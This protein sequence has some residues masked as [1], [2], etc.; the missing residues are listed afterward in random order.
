MERSS[1]ARRFQ[2]KKIT[3]YDVVSGDYP[4][5]NEARMVPH[6][7]EMLLTSSQQFAE[8]L[9]CWLRNG[10]LRPRIDSVL[11]M[12][13]DSFKSDPKQIY[14]YEFAKDGKISR[15]I[16]QKD[17]FPVGVTAD[18]Q[19][20]STVDTRIQNGVS[21]IIIFRNNVKRL[22]TEH[23]GKHAGQPLAGNPL[24]WCEIP[25]Y[26]GDEHQ[27]L[28]LG[29]GRL[30]TG[31]TLVDPTGSIDPDL[32]IHDK[33][34]SLFRQ[35]DGKSMCMQPRRSFYSGGLALDIEI[36]GTTPPDM[37]RDVLSMRRMNR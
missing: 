16:L 35:L 26:G 6:E 23:G 14:A 2:D 12:V 13:S 29:K 37:E 28:H 22:G 31:L 8:H 5:D 21:P 24:N 15:R 3:T 10:G 33:N 17:P 32:A 7:S 19:F 30:G 20:S 1:Q 18:E 9:Y 34:F 36:G 27:A 11:T 4:L 25:E